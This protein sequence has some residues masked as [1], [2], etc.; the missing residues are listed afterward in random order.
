MA[1]RDLIP[2]P[3]KYS[4][5]LTYLLTSFLLINIYGISLNNM[6][7][8]KFLLEGLE[9]YKDTRMKTYDIT[10]LTADLKSSDNLQYSRLQYSTGI[11]NY[12]S[13]YLQY[14]I[15]RYCTA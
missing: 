3:Y 12:V 11:I 14:C 8:L 5:L 15:V 13:L 10:K 1:N 7:K 9:C 6:C 4:D 2:V